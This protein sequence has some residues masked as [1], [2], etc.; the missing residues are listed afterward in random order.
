MHPEFG[1]FE[2]FLGWLFS[3]GW[4][5]KITM[6]DADE[7]WIGDVLKQR[8]QLQSITISLFRDDGTIRITSG[9]SL[10]IVDLRLTLFWEPALPCQQSFKVLP[11][12]PWAFNKSHKVQQIEILTNIAEYCSKIKAKRSHN[13]IVENEFLSFTKLVLNSR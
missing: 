1:L 8:V 13:I 12:R 10:S 6:F 9:L 4:P 3:L 5:R 11:Q 7:I 2:P